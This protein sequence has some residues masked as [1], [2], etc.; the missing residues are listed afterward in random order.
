MKRVIAG[1]TCKAIANQL[2]ISHRTV[3]IHRAHVMDKTGA[4]NLAELARIYWMATPDNM[5]SGAGNTQNEPES[6]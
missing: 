5:E 6:R 1:D 2:D 3:E 4:S